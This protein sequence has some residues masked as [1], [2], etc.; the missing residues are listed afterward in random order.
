MRL[1]LHLQPEDRGPAAGDVRSVHPSQQHPLYRLH[2]QD[3]G[4]QRAPPHAGVP[5]G[6]YLRLQQV[7]SVPLTILVLFSSAILTN[8]RVSNKALEVLSSLLSPETETLEIVCPTVS[9]LICYYSYFRQALTS[10]QKHP[11]I[12]PKYYL[13]LSFLWMVL[14]C[15]VL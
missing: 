6:V 13:I 12:G 7:K 3:A 2:Q 14:K 11:G 4:R 10:R 1:N 5:R 9:L 15:G 8:V